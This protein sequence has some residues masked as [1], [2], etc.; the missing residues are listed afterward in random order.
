MAAA[1][2]SWAL[3][4][5]AFSLVPNALPKFLGRVHRQRRV[6]LIQRIPHVPNHLRLAAMATSIDGSC[7]IFRTSGTARR[8]SSGATRLRARRSSR[9]VRAGL[10]GELLEQGIEPRGGISERCNTWAAC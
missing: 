1:L 4:S 8:S 2:N 7:S 10:D 9:S 5:P 6:G 3:G